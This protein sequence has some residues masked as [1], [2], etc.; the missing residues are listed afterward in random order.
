MNATA[1]IISFPPQKSIF[2]DI[3]ATLKAKGLSKGAKVLWTLLRTCAGQ[4][5]RIRFRLSRLAE[6]IDASV[7]QTKQ[8]VT[9]LKNRGLL[10]ALATPGR[11]NTWVVLDPEP[12]PGPTEIT[13]P[14]DQPDPAGGPTPPS[15]STGYIKEVLKEQNVENVPETREV[16]SVPTSEATQGMDNVNA[17]KIATLEEKIDRLT[18]TVA[19][20]VERNQAPS[21]PST[22]LPP[23]SEPTQEKPKA[24]LSAEQETLVEDIEQTCQ[25]FHSRGQF[26]NIARQCS[27]ETIRQALSQTRHKLATESR[28]N[29]GAYFVATVRAMAEGTCQ[30]TIPEPDPPCTVKPQETQETPITR[31]EPAPTPLPEPDPEPIDPKMLVKGWRLVYEPGKVTRMLRFIAHS[32][33]GCDVQG[34]W[35]ALSKE[36]PG[37]SERSLVEEFLALMALKVEALS[38]SEAPA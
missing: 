19:Q 8:Y 22:P 9:E 35:E 13:Q 24:R 31:S 26:V 38:L 2:S 34:L 36:R 1:Q 3:K 21:P 15:R 27:E 33:T 25:D 14:V 29:G 18:T 37:T 17:V 10:E 30:Q 5:G 23:S 7:S 28:V 6:E 11:S 20:L 32:V 4:K 16:S 12:S